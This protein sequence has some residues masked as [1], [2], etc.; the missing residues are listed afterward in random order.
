MKR[1]LSIFLL[2]LLLT[3]CV[4]G[5][6]SPIPRQSYNPQWSMPERVVHSVFDGTIGKTKVYKKRVMKKAMVPL[7]DEILTGQAPYLVE[8]LGDSVMERRVTSMTVDP[9]IRFTFYDDSRFNYPLLIMSNRIEEYYIFCIVQ[10]FSDGSYATFN[11]L[12]PMSQSILSTGLYTDAEGRLY[13][14]DAFDGTIYELNVVDGVL[15]INYGYSA[16]GKGFATFHDVDFSDGEGTAYPSELYPNGSDVFSKIQIVEETKEPFDAQDME[17]FR[18]SLKPLEVL[19]FSEENFEQIASRYLNDMPEKKSKPDSSNDEKA[20]RQFAAD[21]FSIYTTDSGKECLWIHDYDNN[22]KLAAYAIAQNGDGLKLI[23]VDEN[24]QPREVRG[25]EEDRFDDDPHLLVAGKDAY[26][27]LRKLFT[28]GGTGYL[29]GVKDNEVYEPDISSHIDIFDRV[30]DHFVNNETYLEISE[31]GGG[32]R[33]ERE[34]IYD[35]D[36]KSRQFVK[37]DKGKEPED[38]GGSVNVRIN[39]KD[40]GKMDVIRKDGVNYYPVG[41]MNLLCVKNFSDPKTPADRLTGPNSDPS[42]YYKDT[43]DGTSWFVVA[44]PS[45]GDEFFCVYF[46]EKNLV[47]STDELYYAPEGT[48]EYFR[49]KNKP[50]VK[51]GVLYMDMEALE[52]MFSFDSNEEKGSVII[53]ERKYDPGRWQRITA[54]GY[55]GVF[56][57]VEN[58]F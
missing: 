9:N 57:L 53:K 21:N 34:T 38:K 5:K 15:K 32:V 55:D 44:W 26:L 36:Q 33:K 42:T 37:A 48:Y 50:F 46:A 3:G 29:Y 22:G 27:Y 24:L 18:N 17:N 52:I 1:Y 56:E 12:D 8:D 45:E 4:S 16:D 13:I 39:G 23:Y 51:D 58:E 20:I 19:D 41:E 7:Y 54:P 47:I 43:G 49:P 40:V 35:Y 30:G 10:F 28:T 11:T 31:T 2:F 25:V 6:G 14:D